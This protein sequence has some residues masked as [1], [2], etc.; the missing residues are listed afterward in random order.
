MHSQEAA[1]IS[2]SAEGFVSPLANS[3]DNYAAPEASNG[4][5]SGKGNADFGAPYPSS[6]YFLHYKSSTPDRGCDSSAFF[7]NPRL[8]SRADF[9][10]FAH[11]DAISAPPNVQ[12]RSVRLRDEQADSTEHYEDFTCPHFKSNDPNGPSRVVCAG[13]AYVG[14]KLQDPVAQSSTAS[15]HSCE[16]SASLHEESGDST[17]PCGSS[18][19]FTF[20]L[21]GYE[22]FCDD[23]EG[24]TYIWESKGD[25]TSTHHGGRD[26]FEELVDPC[27]QELD[28][29]VT[30]IVQPC[31][32]EC[33]SVISMV[34]YAASE[35]TSRSDS[36]Y[37]VILM[38]LFEVFELQVH[39]LHLDFS[40]MKIFR[41][42]SF[43]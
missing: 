5:P 41:I 9:S 20:S 10:C 38:S 12:L 40:H 2:K 15:V 28:A 31:S 4:D 43:W 22:D 29:H 33:S 3:A 24:F 23:N 26:P 36:A 39:K 8:Q 37:M 6:C 14:T 42:Y 27:F 35:S 1:H 18:E 11:P 21:A 13:S 32:S 16:E 17:E 25:A 7:E 34:T 19:H 30:S